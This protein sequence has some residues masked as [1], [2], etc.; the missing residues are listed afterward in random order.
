MQIVFVLKLSV[1]FVS[2]GYQALFEVSDI[3]P[4]FLWIVL[5]LLIVLNIFLNQSPA[6]LY[7]N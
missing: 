1:L 3:I 2:W 5:E 4:K 7:I 6:F